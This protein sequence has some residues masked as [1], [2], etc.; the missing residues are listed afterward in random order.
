MHWLFLNNRVKVGESYFHASE[1]EATEKIEKLKSQ[2]ESKIEEISSE[3]SNIQREMDEL[4]VDLYLK[5]G[6]NINLDE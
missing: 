5:F 4:K 2:T 1:D 3:L 6:S